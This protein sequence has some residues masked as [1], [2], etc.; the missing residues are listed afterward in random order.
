MV[1]WTTDGPSQQMGNAF[2]KNLVLRQ[3]D[4]VE[5]TLGFQ[6]LVDVRGG[7]G[8][9][10]PEVA[11][12][13]PFPVTLNDGF[14]NLTPTIGAMNIAGTQGASFQITELVKQE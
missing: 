13:V 14:K 12:Q 2:L 8:G 7:E 10:P 5:K 9:I 1:R 6:K 11:T 4:R 3:T